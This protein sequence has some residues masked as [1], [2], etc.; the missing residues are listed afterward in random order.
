VDLSLV[1]LSIWVRSLFFFVYWNLGLDLWEI[2]VL[3]D[4]LDLE[5]G[6]L[7]PDGPVLDNL[8]GLE[9]VCYFDIGFAHHFETFYL[10]VLF[11]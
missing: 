6:E 10:E 5:V 1:Y 7:V 2:V 8:V 9:A 4:L 3:G 11:L